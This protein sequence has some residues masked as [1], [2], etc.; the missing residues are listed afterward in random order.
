MEI[1]EEENKRFFAVVKVENL[2]L[3]EYIE[4]TRLHSHISSAVDEAIDN[5]RMY[6]KNQGIAG[7]FVT[8]IQVFAKEETVIRLVETIKA[9][10]KA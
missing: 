5:I 10:I 7:K 1:E 6:L 8:N 3:P 2:E 4:K 9:K